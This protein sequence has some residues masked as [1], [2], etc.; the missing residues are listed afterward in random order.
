M[1]FKNLKVFMQVLI[2]KRLYG[3]QKLRAK[4]ENLDATRNMFCAALLQ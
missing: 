2:V 3:D 4:G 1:N